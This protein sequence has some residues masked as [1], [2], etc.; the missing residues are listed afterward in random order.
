MYAARV[1]RPKSGL[2]REIGKEGQHTCRIEPLSIQPGPNGRHG[3]SFRSL[4][5][6]AA[7]WST[8]GWCPCRP[9]RIEGTTFGAWDLPSVRACPGFTRRGGCALTAV[10]RNAGSA[11]FRTI[12]QPA[13]K[14]SSKR[15]FEAQSP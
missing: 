4:A 6:V 2:D 9:R 11:P 1:D 7:R 8:G 12:G 3:T 13:V 10:L 5:N 15:T 14:T